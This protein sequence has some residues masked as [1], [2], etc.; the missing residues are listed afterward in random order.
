M[1][2]QVLLVTYEKFP[3]LTADDRLLLAA[4]ENRGMSVRAACWEDP[5]VDWANSSVAVIRSTWDYFVRV[6]EFQHHCGSR[7]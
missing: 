3:N 2:P 1:I 5:L 6:H 4:L 7:E